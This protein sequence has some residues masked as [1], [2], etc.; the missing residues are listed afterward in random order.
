M[1]RFPTTLRQFL[2]AALIGHGGKIPW[3]VSVPAEIRFQREI[4]T[5]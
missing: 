4:T 1:Y 5:Q 3:P 2:D